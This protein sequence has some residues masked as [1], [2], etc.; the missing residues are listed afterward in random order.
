VAPD[1]TPE[2]KAEKRRI[3]QREYQRQWKKDNAAKTREI[4]RKSIS[5]H[6]EKRNERYRQWYADNRERILAKER[7]P[8]K[9]AKYAEYA[10]KWREANPEKITQLNVKAKERSSHWRAENPE[11]LREQGRQWRAKNPERARARALAAY[12]KQRAANPEK[13]R[14]RQRKRRAANP[15]EVRGDN[16]RRRA[17]YQGSYTPDDIQRLFDSQQGRCAACGVVLE[18]SGRGK[19]H[20]DHIV[21]LKPRKGFPAGTNDPNNLQLLC[22]P[23]N[24]S[25]HNQDQAQW[26]AR[27]RRL[28]SSS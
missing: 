21:P 14:E 8:E 23:C 25:K 20:I 15:D 24:R 13:L 18:T 26:M 3:Y 17:R 22:M 4:N 5:K 12:Y 6:R 2:Q 7:T 28:T 10:R 11:R 9:R 16:H 1:L 19:Y 27:K